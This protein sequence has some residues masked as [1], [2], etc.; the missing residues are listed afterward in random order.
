MTQPEDANN[1]VQNAENQSPSQGPAE[2]LPDAVPEFVSDVL[3]SISVSETSLGETISTLVSN[4]NSTEVAALSANVAT[5]I[6]L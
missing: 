2:G 5:A 4:A 3:D 6:P 1:A